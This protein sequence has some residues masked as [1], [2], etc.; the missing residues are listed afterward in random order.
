M[1]ITTDVSITEEH[2]MLRDTVRAFAND[3]L[4]PQAIEIDRDRRFPLDAFK[5][6]A[7]NPLFDMIKMQ[8]ELVRK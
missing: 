8:V 5:Q 2:E 3:V 1:T 7:K 4:L 6:M